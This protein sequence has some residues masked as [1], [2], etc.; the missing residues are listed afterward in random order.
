SEDCRVFKEVFLPELG[1]KTFE[2]Q[3]EQT[4]DEVLVIFHYCPLVNAWKKLGFS[5]ERIAKLCD[6]AMEGDRGIAANNELKFELGDTIASGC[7]T[8]K[9]TMS[10]G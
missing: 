8:C 9:M 7:A 10:R 2:M 3:T 4:E 6:I 1:L 5:D